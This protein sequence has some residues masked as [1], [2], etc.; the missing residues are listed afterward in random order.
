MPTTSKSHTLLTNILV[1]CTYISNTMQ[2]ST[3]TLLASIM[4]ATCAVAQNTGACGFDDYNSQYFCIID[5]VVSLDI[6][7]EAGWRRA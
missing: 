3:L 1:L 5:G 2:F 7:T 6:C 4:A